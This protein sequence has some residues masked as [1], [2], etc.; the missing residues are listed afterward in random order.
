[1][2]S[3]DVNL[4]PSYFERYHWSHLHQVYGYPADTFPRFRWIKSLENRG[5]W[6]ASMG[7]IETAPTNFIRELLDWGGGAGPRM[8]FEAKLGNVCLQERFQLVVDNI[9]NVSLALEHALR[10]PGC[11]LTYGSKLLRFLKPELH[12]SLDSRIRAALLKAGLL[13][14]IYDSS[15]TSMIRGY[16]SFIEVNSALKNELELAGINRPAC[17]LPPGKSATG[18]RAADIEMA[19]FAWAD[20]KSRNPKFGT[21]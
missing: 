5:S 11:G 20:K 16:V 1:M 17:D 10:I 8:K 15:D 19:L 12:A 13:G 6:L 3:I 4:L 2:S 21:G 14:E 7:A 9:D 18:W